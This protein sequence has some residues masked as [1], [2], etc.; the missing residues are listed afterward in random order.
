MIRFKSNQIPK[1]TTSQRSAL[2]SVPSGYLVF[3]TSEL[4]YYYNQAAPGGN[5]SWVVIAT[6]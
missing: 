3:D 4:K 6:A 1:M 5:P 2:T